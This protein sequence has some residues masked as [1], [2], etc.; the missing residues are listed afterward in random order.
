LLKEKNNYILNQNIDELL[1][2]HKF[3]KLNDFLK[4]NESEVIQRNLKD[5]N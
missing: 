4:R 5:N 2:N 3:K 1:K